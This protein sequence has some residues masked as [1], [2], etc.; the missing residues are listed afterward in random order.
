[1]DLPQASAGSCT[2]RIADILRVLDARVAESGP[3]G[4][5]PQPGGMGIALSGESTGHLF[6]SEET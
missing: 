5:S 1:M 2:R 3:E 4:L 6:V